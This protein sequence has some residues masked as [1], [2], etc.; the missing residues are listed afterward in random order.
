MSESAIFNTVF[1]H[2]SKIIVGIAYLVVDEIAVRVANRLDIGVDK[3]SVGLEVQ[4]LVA[5]EHLAVEILVDIDGVGLHQS[6][7]SLVI[8]FALDPLDLAQKLA[9]ALP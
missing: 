4:L 1:K 2:L 9:E 5:L 7:A 6:L 3:S 8:P